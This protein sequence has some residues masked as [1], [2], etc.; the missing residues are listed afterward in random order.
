LFDLDAKMQSHPASM[1]P[2]ETAA[3]IPDC[4][5]RHQHFPVRIACR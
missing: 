4:S 5:V 2:A 3:T 1:A